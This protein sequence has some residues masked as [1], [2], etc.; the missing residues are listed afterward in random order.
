MTMSF[1][2]LK[3][4]LKLSLCFFC[5]SFVSFNSENK[6]I[7]CLDANENGRN[8]FKSFDRKYLFNYILEFQFLSFSAFVDLIHAFNFI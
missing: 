1:T 2:C 4:C 7:F 8:S 6:R 5:M 3:G